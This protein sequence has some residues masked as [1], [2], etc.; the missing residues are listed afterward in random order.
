[1]LI[2]YYMDNKKFVNLSAEYKNFLI[3]IKEINIS[4]DNLDFNEL[5]DLHIKIQNYLEEFNLQI[6]DINHMM[7]NY[8]KTNNQIEMLI[9]LVYYRNYNYMKMILRSGCWK[10]FIIKLR[11]KLQ[12]KRK[13]TIKEIEEVFIKL[14][15]RYIGRWNSLD[16]FI[17]MNKKNQINEIEIIDP[18]DY[19]YIFDELI[20]YK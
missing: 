15:N 7:E 14:L 16:K 8:E 17:V 10:D 2:I 18:E 4:F 9:K 19:K 20:K 11:M 13:L 3:K 5:N 1:M 6:S 12:D